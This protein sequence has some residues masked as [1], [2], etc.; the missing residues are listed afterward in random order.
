MAIIMIHH[1]KNISTAYP[2]VQTGTMPMIIGSPMGRAMRVMSSAD[3]F[4]PAP[5]I[6]YQAASPTISAAAPTTIH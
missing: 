4:M 1:M 6:V 2:G 5:A 3:I